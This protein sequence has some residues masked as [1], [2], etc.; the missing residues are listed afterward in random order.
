MWRNCGGYIRYQGPPGDHLRPVQDGHE[1]AAGPCGGEDWG[2][3]E[4]TKKNLIII[5]NI[6]IIFIIIR[7]KLDVS[8]RLS[9]LEVALEAETEEEDQSEG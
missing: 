7:W 3:S 6:I 4:V 5:I 8:R 2:Q 9:D 1:Q